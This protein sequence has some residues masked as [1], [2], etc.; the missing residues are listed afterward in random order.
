MRDELVSFEMLDNN[1]KILVTYVYECMLWDLEKDELLTKWYFG[2]D[3]YN[4][5]EYN[6]D[7]S[8]MLTYNGFEMTI[9]DTQ[10]GLILFDK[11]PSEEGISYYNFAGTFSRDERY[12]IHGISMER[13]DSWENMVYIYVFLT[14]DDL[15]NNCRKHIGNRELTQKE[16]IEFYLEDGKRAGF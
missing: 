11:S 13:D 2:N 3:R 6:S 5:I 8:K 16:K 14:L 12:I 15:I 9:Y 4:G 10:S 1:R 7:K